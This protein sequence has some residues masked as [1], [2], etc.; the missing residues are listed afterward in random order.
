MIC[1]NDTDL[2][3]AITRINNASAETEHLIIVNAVNN[4][5]VQF[6][7]DD[8]IKYLEQRNS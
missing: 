5:C 6:D 7:S 2:D 4:Y 8:I 1:Y 3:K